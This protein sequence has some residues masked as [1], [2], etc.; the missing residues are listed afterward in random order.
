MRESTAM[1]QSIDRVIGVAAGLSGAAGVAL[2][3]AGA[4]AAPGSNLD[5]AG[6]MLILH[7]AALLALAGVSPGSQPI[8]RLAA[9]VMIIG[10]ALFAGDLSA[11]AF[12]GRHLFPMAAPLG[13]LSLI[14]AWIVAALSFLG[15]RRGE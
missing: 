1:A 10:L 7:G 11:R 3:A 13:G 12:L 6:T 15:N 2:S 8:R 4:H 14:A 5:T 9:V